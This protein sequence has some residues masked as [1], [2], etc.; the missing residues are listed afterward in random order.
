MCSFA[1]S[2]RPTTRGG[3]LCIQRAADWVSSTH[4]RAAPIANLLCPKRDLRATLFSENSPRTN[5]WPI[6]AFTYGMSS[7][8]ASSGSTSRRPASQIITGDS[9]YPI[10]FFP[11][12]L[13][14]A[15]S[16]P[17]EKLPNFGGARGPASAPPA[18]TTFALH[19]SAARSAERFVKRRRDLMRDAA[20]A[21]R[22]HEYMPL[23]RG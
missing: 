2:G 21:S 16:S 17:G 20:R 22:R 15:P 12:R 6:P 19:R 13:P 1:I 18:G 11:R 8:L 10:G 14:S 4:S 7:A 9:R 23:G 5:T 3:C